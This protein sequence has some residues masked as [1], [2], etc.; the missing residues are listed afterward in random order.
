LISSS[1]IYITMVLNDS[2]FSSILR[3]IVEHAIHIA[4]K[5]YGLNI[6]YREIVDDVE[7]PYII[8]NDM[9]PIVFRDL[10]SMNELINTLILISELNSVLNPQNSSSELAWL[11]A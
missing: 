9:N 11:N 7:T 10:P 4:V 6:K 5:E 1:V 8:I 2:E 3:E